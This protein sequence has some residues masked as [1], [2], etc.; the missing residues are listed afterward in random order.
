MKL[1][2][3]NIIF[4]GFFLLFS[5]AK[6]HIIPVVADFS[7]QVENED[8]SVPVRVQIIN[9]TQG[10]DT[11]QWSFEGATQKKSSLKTPKPIVYTQAGEYTIWLK[12]SNK[13]GAADEKKLI[14]TVD[15]AMKV[16]FS[17]E[18]K[19]SGISPV[20]IQLVNQ[21]QGAKNYLW[22]FENGIPSTSDKKSPQVLFTQAGT[23][24]IELTISNGKETYTSH[25]KIEILPAMH[26]DFDWS[27]DFID[28]DYQAPVTLLL[29]NKS[30]Q[31]TEYRWEIQGAEPFNPKE[32][33]PKIT[34]TQPGT[35]SITLYASN[36]KE[37]KKITKKITILPN[38]NLLSFSDVKLGFNTAHASIG[39]FFSSQLGKVL[40]QKEVTPEN[41][42]W[43][44]FAYF[45][46]NSIFSYNQFL[47]PDQVQNSAFIA[48]SGATHTQIVNRQELIKEQLSVTKFESI[49]Q[50]KDFSDI[51]VSSSAK[52]AFPFDAQIR[53]RLVL[54]QTQDGRKGAIK[55][56]NFISDGKQSYIL[57]DIKVQKTAQ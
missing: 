16:A 39:C 13:D 50:G 45:G 51:I 29:N 53:P 41:G 37:T 12:A 10:A 11:Y 26:P 22:F 42:K 8:Y 1:G 6:E 40:T 47:S 25:K 55:I 7:I 27:V 3:K 57:T 54:F 5:C 18:R 31:S 52:G 33:N 14:I 32:Q 15:E 35:F 4:I 46:L 9:R 44:D 17:W 24:R 48:I 56:K 23:H 30:T 2:I 49:K 36:D 21:S 34:F 43:I 19:G 38:K 20:S 28:K